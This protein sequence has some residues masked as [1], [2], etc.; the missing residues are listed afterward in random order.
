MHLELYCVMNQHDA[1]NY[2]Q[3]IELSRLNMFQAQ[4]QEVECI[5]VASGTCV[6]CK[7]SV[8]GSGWNKY[9]LPHIYILP[10][11]DGL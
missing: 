9:H 6:T 3:F 4:H 10:P 7:S 2:L 11:D 1:I 8:G 5:Y